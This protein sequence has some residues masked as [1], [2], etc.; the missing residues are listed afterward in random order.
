MNQTT[1]Q[2]NK[3][4][5]FAY[6]SNLNLRQMKNRCPL[7]KKVGSGVIE[8]YRLCF[9]GGYQNKYLTIQ[10]E[11]HQAVPV[12]IFEV[13]PSDEDSL[14]CYEGYP[15]FYDKKEFTIKATI[16]G[17]QKEIKG[18]AYVM[19]D[20]MEYGRP[21]IEYVLIVAEGYCNFG[22]SMERLSEAYRYSVGQ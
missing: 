20:G 6:G 14:D 13:C 17:E 15:S 12:G 10:S 9:R 5:Y 4:Y 3:R 22:F 18:F 19:R 16:D 8:D 2:P 7:A 1:K 21:H 11:R